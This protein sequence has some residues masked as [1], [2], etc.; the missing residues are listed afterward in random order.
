LQEDGEK[1]C[2]YSGVYAYIT[3]N[4]PQSGLDD[5]LSAKNRAFL[6]FLLH[7]DYVK[8][9]HSILMLQ[10][11]FLQDFELEPFYTE[12]DYTHLRGGPPKSRVRHTTDLIPLLGNSRAALA[13]WEDLCARMARD[14]KQMQL[15]VVVIQ[16]GTE[17]WYLMFPMRSNSAALWD[18][19][20]AV[21]ERIFE[22][23]DLDPR[24]YAA[25]MR[26]LVDGQGDDVVELH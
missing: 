2:F 17:P 21:V 3:L 4:T 15:H 11:Q 22:D 26:A 12:F 25:A 1:R 5:D 14:P 6:R 23:E 7:H 18:G 8:Q 20:A 10:S 9:K 16:R 24:E 19:L 13:R